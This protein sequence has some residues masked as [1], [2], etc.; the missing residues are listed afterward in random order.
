MTHPEVQAL[1]KVVSLTLRKYGEQHNLNMEILMSEAE[2]DSTSATF[3]IMIRD[4]SKTMTASQVSFYKNCSLYG[5]TAD[6]Y[7]A[8]VLVEG[9]L[10]ELWDINPRSELSPILARELSTGKIFSFPAGITMERAD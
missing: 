7:K 9:R 6:D 1:R 4:C 2:M 3:Q 5:L 10:L 8:R